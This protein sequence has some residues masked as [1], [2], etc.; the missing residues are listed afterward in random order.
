MA[1]SMKLALV[2]LGIRQIEIVRA[3]A[4][5]GLTLNQGYLCEII[6]GRARGSEATRGAIVEALVQ[7]GVARETAIQLLPK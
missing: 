5:K 2:S 4:R 7:L 3:A 1:T 6:N